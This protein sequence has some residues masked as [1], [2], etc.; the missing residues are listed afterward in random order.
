MKKLLIAGAI[1][2]ATSAPA[3]AQTLTYELEAEVGVVCGVYKFDGPAV[4]VDF[5]DLSNT[6]TGAFVEAGAG[7]ASYRCNSAN[8]FDRTISSANGGNL[9]RTGSSGGA[10]NTIPFEM[11]HGGGSGLATGG[12]VALTSPITTSLGGSTAFLNGQTGS[13]NFRV[14]GVEAAPGPNE[15]PGT[16]VFAGDY[17]DIVTIA[18][19]A[20]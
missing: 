11:S 4:T 1:A 2:A 8:G 17:T 16:T 5:A 19:T 3:Y 7:S 13:V 18:I 14:A 20:N 9:V 10:G 12:Y 6:D 15:A